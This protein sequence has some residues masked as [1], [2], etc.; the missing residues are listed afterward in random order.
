MKKF[1]LATVA[2]VALG[3]TVPALAADLAARPYTKAPAY[4][5]APIYNWTGF[6]IGG[7]LGGAFAGDRNF[8]GLTT[9]D[10]ARFMG[11]VQGGADYQFAPNWVLG[12]E[13]QY[14]WLGN[15]NNA[16]AFTGAGAG[17][18][19]N[20]NQRAIG[21]AT[22]RLGYTWGPALLYVKGG[23]ANG[24]INA[25]Y[26]AGGTTTKDGTNSDG[27]RVGTGVELPVAKNMLVRAEYRYTNY[28]DT[29]LARHQGLIGFG[30][31]F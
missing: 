30:V 26:T 6:Y 2:L 14:S 20:N 18:I 21:S 8:T 4:S 24:R 1:L 5:A 22:G 23:Y 9:T 3:A 11:G 12:V 19:Y 7:H 29:D 27:W 15:N 17:F 31:K 28:S 13:G 16:V 10:D 25:T